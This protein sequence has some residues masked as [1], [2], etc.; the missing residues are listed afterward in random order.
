MI[1]QHSFIIL[2]CELNYFMVLFYIAH[3]LIQQR[4]QACQSFFLR[5]NG[6]VLQSPLQLPYFFWPSWSAKRYKTTSHDFSIFLRSAGVQDAKC[7]LASWQ[8]PQPLLQLR[9]S[10]W[11]PL[12]GETSHELTNFPSRSRLQCRCT[13]RT[14]NMSS[15]FAC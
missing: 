15:I 3:R 4:L 6:S 14:H 8:A 2:F 10:G 13:A 5:L 12:T 9:L 1:V 7:Y 11:F